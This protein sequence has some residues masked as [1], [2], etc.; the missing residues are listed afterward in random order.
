MWILNGLMKENKS[1]TKAECQCHK[2][3]ESANKTEQSARQSINLITWSFSAQVLWKSHEI[4]GD[5]VWD[6][7][8]ESFCTTGSGTQIQNVREPGQRLQADESSIWDQDEFDRSSGHFGPGSN[9]QP[10]A[11]HAM[12]ALKSFSIVKHLFISSA[13]VIIHFHAQPEKCPCI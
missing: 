9:F 13:K 8:L 2:S 4:S 11:K 12:N 1:F 7:S 5:I 6:R 3:E 10:L